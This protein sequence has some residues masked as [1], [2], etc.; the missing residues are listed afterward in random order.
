MQNQVNPDTTQG[1]SSTTAAAE[2]VFGTKSQ[3]LPSSGNTHDPE[4]HVKAFPVGTS[5]LP[6]PAKRVPLQW[7]V[8]VPLAIGPTRE[9]CPP[10][11]T[12]LTPSQELREKVA[13]AAL[14]CDAPSFDLGFDSLQN[15][16]CAISSNRV[17]S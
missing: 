15:R 3:H 5:F 8:P 1:K 10:P 4:A 17:F 7:G 13:R 16:P 6:D 11:A 12:K 14:A 2:G 9:T